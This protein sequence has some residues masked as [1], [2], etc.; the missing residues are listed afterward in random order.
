M[1]A[2]LATALAGTL[3]AAA[4]CSSSGGSSKAPSKATLQKVVVQQSD[5]PSGWKGSPP[6]IEASQVGNVVSAVY[7]CIGGTTINNK[8]EI[9]QVN[10]DDFT[11]GQNTIS[12]SATSFKTQQEIDNRVKLLLDP[13]ADACFTS[14]LKSTL[15]KVVPGAKVASAQ[16]HVVKGYP[17]APSNVAASATAQLALS[18]AGQTEPIY[19]SAAFIKGTLLGATVEFLGVGSP[20]DASVQT[21]AVTD[22]ANRVKST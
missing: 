22:V 11:Q 14:T 19:L 12:S 13:K 5:L 3:V 7:T 4:A 2:L 1:K 21:K 20:I 9:E 15:G 10:G 18:I 8:N 17:G 6:S 16:V